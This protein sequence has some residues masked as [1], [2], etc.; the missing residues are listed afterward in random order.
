W[1]EPLNLLED[2]TRPSNHRL[3]PQRNRSSGIDFPTFKRP[4][5]R[6]TET[7]LRTSAEPMEDGCPEEEKRRLI[8]PSIYSA[9]CISPTQPFVCM[10]Q[11]YSGLRT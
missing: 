7:V 1:T 6:A 10:P 3:T 4:L 9:L 8:V 11:Y 2:L 5:K